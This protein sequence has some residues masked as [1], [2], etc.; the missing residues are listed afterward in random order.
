MGFAMY[1]NGRG[2]DERWTRVGQGLSPRQR[3]P[4]VPPAAKQGAEIPKAYRVDV[5]LLKL[6]GG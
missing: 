4:S 2:L 6:P 5:T 1:M 3:T